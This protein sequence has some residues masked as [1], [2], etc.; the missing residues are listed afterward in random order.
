[1]T[2]LQELRLYLV[3]LNNDQVQTL[4]KYMSQS[5]KLNEIS[6][7]SFNVSTI[8]P[9]IFG[10]AITNIGDVYLEKVEISSNQM[11]SIFTEMEQ[12]RLIRSFV[13]LE[14]NVNMSIVE[15]KL[16]AR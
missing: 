9:D 3:S 14:A 11:R 13:S 2:G 12:K 15:S 6:L 4:F 1:M 10:K 8:E 5:N 16:F 7:S